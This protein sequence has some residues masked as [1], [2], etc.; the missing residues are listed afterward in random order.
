MNQTSVPGARYDRV[1]VALHWFVGLWLLGQ[2]AFGWALG[3]IARGTPER[4]LAVNLHK[5]S[6][7]V[8]ALFIAWRVL[9]RLRHAPP[10]YPAALS[11]MQ[12]RIARGGHALLY[13]CMVAM[14]LTGYLASNFSKHGI[15]FFNAYAL[16][17]WGP[18]DK[19]LYGLFNGAHDALA[20]LFSL[21]VAGHVLLGLHHAFIARDGLFERMALR[22]RPDR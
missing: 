16:A 22:A 8:L 3:L 20:L 13:A 1:A 14:P 15:N 10:G 18:D 11:A 4:G 7:L 2:I 6:G 9:W 21:L 12:Q 19:S 17:P 5:S